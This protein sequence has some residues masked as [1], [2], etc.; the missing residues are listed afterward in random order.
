MCHSNAYTH[1]H[2]NV[3]ALF[4]G[5]L[6]FVCVRG[7]CSSIHSWLVWKWLKVECAKA[8]QR[9]DAKRTTHLKNTR[10]F[11]KKKKIIKWQC[12]YVVDIAAA[13]WSVTR[14]QWPILF[15]LS[16]IFVLLLRIFLAF[17]CDFVVIVTVAL[18][19]EAGTKEYANCLFRKKRRLIQWNNTVKSD[20]KAWIMSWK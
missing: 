14:V 6:I 17:Y 19:T 2:I 3:H 11:Y 7:C 15:F 4:F 16:I 20:A 9:K 18:T 12:V 10:K 8:Q 5:Y 1:A 13:L